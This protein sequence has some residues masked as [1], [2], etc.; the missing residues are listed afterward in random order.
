MKTMS[1]KF[2]A[3]A[4][5][6]ALCGSAIAQQKTHDPMAGS[7]AKDPIEAE[8]KLIDA[9][10]DGKVSMAE[11]TMGAQEMFKGMDGNQDNRVSAAEMDATQP[12]MKSQ[13]AAHGADSH[14]ADHKMSHEM[15]S[16][17][18][19]K[20]LDT[21]GDGFLTAQEHEAG[22]KKMF[23]KMDKDQDGFLTA[24]EIKEGHHQMMMS[25]DR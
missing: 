17:Q 16:A 8:M 21:D 25:D 19:I 7:G 18:K 14:G 12:A 15:S 5:A 6:T 3:V 23:T 22:A 4:V 11:H 2:L 24:A 9:N 20:K 13:D 10:K 1:G